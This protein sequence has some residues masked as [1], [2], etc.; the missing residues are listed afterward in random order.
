MTDLTDGVVKL[1]PSSSN[2]KLQMADEGKG[3]DINICST[4]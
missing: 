1:F 4:L 2:A 3:V